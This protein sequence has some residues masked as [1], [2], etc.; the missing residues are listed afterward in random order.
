M[1]PLCVTGFGVAEVFELWIRKG[2]MEPQAFSAEI[3]RAFGIIGGSFYLFF[4]NSFFIALTTYIII[5]LLRFPFKSYVD[6]REARR[7]R[8]ITAFFS[9]LVSLPS[10]IILYNLYEMQQDKAEVKAFVDTYFPQAC[11][12]YELTSIDRDTNKLILQLLGRRISEDSV[13]YY[14]ELLHE[15]YDLNTP[16]RLFPMQ[17]EMSLEDIK[18]SLQAQR[19]EVVKMLETERR[20]ANS[21]VEETEALR[22]ALARRQSDST[23]I[24]KSLRVA[25]ESFGTDIQSIQFAPEAR[26]VN[27]S[28]TV[29]LP[30]VFMVDWANRRGT[31]VN[32][33]RLE[34]I[35][36]ISAELDTLQLISY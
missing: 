20:T 30:P 26:T 5:R 8:M 32:K 16:V 9:L 13:L 28:A 10:G 33:E 29:S 6:A 19:Q 23:L 7:N 3:N 18:T 21:A 14:Q 34:R 27:D 35:L 1:P 24:A 12:N 4:L 2:S 11:I 25:R 31:A 15:K 17:A 22:R 36:R